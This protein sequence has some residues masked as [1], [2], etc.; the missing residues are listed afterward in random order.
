M[1]IIL[2]KGMSSRAQLYL[3]G[4]VAL[5][6]TYRRYLELSI[7][8]PLL[9]IARKPISLYMTKPSGN[10]TVLNTSYSSNE[11]GESPKF[12]FLLWHEL[13]IIHLQ[14]KFTE[15][16]LNEGEFGREHP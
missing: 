15:K 7:L 10:T 2:R 12:F 6:S 11:H 5:K 4:L 14:P 1:R 13:V 9:L 3:I 8:L 16:K